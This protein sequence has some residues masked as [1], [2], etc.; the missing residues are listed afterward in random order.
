MR[1]RLARRIDRGPDLAG[2][3]KLA[4]L[5]EV[6][7]QQ[8]CLCRA[9]SVVRRD[10]PLSV[11]WDRSRYEAPDDATLY[12]L[13]RELEFKTLLAKLS[14]PPDLPLFE[15]VTKL[16]GNYRSYVHGPIHPSSPHSLASS[17]GMRARRASLSRC[18]AMRSGSRHGRGR[19]GFRHERARARRRAR[20]RGAD[21]RCAGRRG[22]YD[23]KRLTHVL[24]T[25]AVAGVE[26]SDD[27]MIGAHL[28]DPSHGFADVE[29]AA[30]AF[31]G[32]DLPE[33]PPP[34]PTRRSSLS[35]RLAASSNRAASSRS[36]RLE[37]PLAPV[38]AKMERAGVAMIPKSCA[39]SASVSTLGRGAASA[40]LRSLRRGVQHRFAQQLGNVLFGKLQIPGSKKT[41]TGWA[42]G[43]EVLQSLAREYPICALVLEWREVTKLRTPTLT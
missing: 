6:Y 3:P 34:P 7:G 33:M 1:R 27:A 40:D 12:P 19:S 28:L 36:T 29:D 2:N 13:F 43:V 39:S 4:R 18:S 25:A 30:A 31:L 24:E 11:D 26:F 37:L 9:V 32:L 42:T 5:I 35:R 41:K 8:A 17:K 21:L 10:L 38:L 20:C 22:G 14:A 16:T 15:A 23:V